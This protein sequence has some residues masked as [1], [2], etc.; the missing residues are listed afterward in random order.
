M[1]SFR[2][3]YNIFLTAI[4]CVL[5]AISVAFGI[6]L[7]H[8]AFPESPE[9][10]VLFI[11]AF[12]L[13]LILFPL[14]L[15]S[16][17][18]RQLPRPAQA[19]FYLLIAIGLALLA[20]YFYWVSEKVFFPADILIWSETDFVTGLIKIAKGY[21]F[22]TS[23]VLNES[24]NYTPGAP[25]IAYLI[26]KAVGQPFSLPFYRIL[27]LVFVLIASG[28]AVLCTNL[29]IEIGFP[30]QASKKGGWWNAL[31][32]VLLFLIAT[33][34]I[35]NPYVHN[36]HNEA[37]ALLLLILAFLW[38]ILYV[39]TGKWWYLVLMAITPALGFW[40]KQYLAVWVVF[41]TGYLLFFDQPRSYK[42]SLIFGLT[43]F[44]LLVFSMSLGYLIWKGDYIYW[45]FTVIYK[46]GN[47]ILRMF[48]NLTRVWPYA[49]MGLVCGLL[50]NWEK[51]GQKLLGL[52]IIW[53]L[54]FFQEIY[55]S[56]IA[57]MLHHMGPGSLIAG[58][59]MGVSLFI[60]WPAMTRQRI[61]PRALMQWSRIGILV[62]CFVLLAQGLGFLRIP[63]RTLGQDAYRYIHQVEQEFFG[64][65][66]EKV[67]LDAGSWVYLKDKIVMKDRAVSIGDR[68]FAGI[69]D[70]SGMIQRIENKEYDKILFRK[71]LE[72]D[73]WYD[74][75]DWQRSS[76][77]NQA[78]QDNYRVI[79]VIP[80]VSYLNNYL[81]SEIS[82]LEPKKP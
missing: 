67:L 26:A 46:H 54:L 33:N 65:P 56:G 71:Y 43:S 68:G 30:E 78:L 77:I 52:W 53:L 51:H 14:V 34:A 69:G 80:P 70:F 42:R 20:I 23:E 19:G 82:V 1:S 39:K 72:P 38:L 73:N 47:S 21:P 15:Y 41:Y 2:L 36:L 62:A 5:V 16:I 35:T 75:A 24:N 76:G 7:I 3:I 64:L 59:W 9:I 22:F 29:L 32:F 63:V 44:T 74:N 81:F 58:I 31:W 37:L 49:F 40:V 11:A 48:Q 28:I 25:A 17:L 18:K 50:L 4:A 61:N 13:F 45:V 27:H 57:W 66:A 60:Y 55:T 79:R 12:L 6:Y 10:A 8:K